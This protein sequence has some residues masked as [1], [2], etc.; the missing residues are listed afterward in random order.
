METHS[1]EPESR[2]AITYQTRTGVPSPSPIS[3]TYKPDSTNIGQSDFGT[4]YYYRFSNDIDSSNGI[5]GFAVAG[6]SY[7]IDGTVFWLPDLSS[8]SSGTGNLSI[9][10]ITAAVS[11]LYH[12]F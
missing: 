3:A 9:V 1:N 2:L 7:S 4:T 6:N 5:S 8:V 11:F 12:A 10:N